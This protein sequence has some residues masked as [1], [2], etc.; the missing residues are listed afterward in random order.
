MCYRQE[1][2]LDIL[3]ANPDSFRLT[4]AT[5][6]KIEVFYN[7]DSGATPESSKKQVTVAL[8]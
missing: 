1:I 6:L 8:T 5:I 4:F 2:H 7:I 3:I